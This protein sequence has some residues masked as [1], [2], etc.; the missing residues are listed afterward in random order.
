MATQAKNPDEYVAM[1]VKTGTVAK[2]GTAKRA[3]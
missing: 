3:K 2:I 1:V